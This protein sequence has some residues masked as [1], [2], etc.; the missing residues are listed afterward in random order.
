MMGEKSF[1][2]LM[3]SVFDAYEQLQEETREAFDDGRKITNKITEDKSVF[4]DIKKETKILSEINK[5]LSNASVMEPD[6]FR[7]LLRRTLGNRYGKYVKLYKRAYEEGWDVGMITLM[8]GVGKGLSD[9]LGYETNEQVRMLLEDR[10]HEYLQKNPNARRQVLVRLE[11]IRKSKDGKL[12]SRTLSMLGVPRGASNLLG[13]ALD[14][15]RTFYRNISEW[16]LK[17]YDQ[18]F[19]NTIL[20]IKEKVKKGM[21]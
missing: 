12:L 17:E 11:N 7:G 13:R 20:E 6:E 19:D 1:L 21:I 10:I 2:Y 4:K 3:D 18:S 16:T 9:D 15:V 8:R 5:Y 14:E